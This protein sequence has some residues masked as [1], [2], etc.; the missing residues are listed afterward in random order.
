MGKVKEQEI[1]TPDSLIELGREI[2]KAVITHMK[3]EERKAVIARMSPEERKAVIAHMSPEERK[4]V[5]AAA[6]LEERL[7]GLTPEEMTKLIEQI[8][9]SLQQSN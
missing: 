8:S 3:P 5:I 2:R 1:I 7:I 9:A 4:A 6:P